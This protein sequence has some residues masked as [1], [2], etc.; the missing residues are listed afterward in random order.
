M[1]L[2]SHTLPHYLV[3]NL[4]EQKVDICVIQVLLGHRQFKH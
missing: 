4:R 3:A 2:F 1:Q